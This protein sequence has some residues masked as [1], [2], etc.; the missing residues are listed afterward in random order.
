MG[1]VLPTNLDAHPLI[2]GEFYGIFMETES[3]EWL[4]VNCI[5]L[6]STQKKPEKGQEGQFHRI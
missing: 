2:L 4:V 5:L 3:L 6:K 1:G